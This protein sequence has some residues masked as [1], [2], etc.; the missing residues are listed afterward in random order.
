CS[1]ERSFERPLLALAPSSNAE[2]HNNPDQ[3][4]RNH[5]ND[6][7]PKVAAS[8]YVA[9]ADTP[10]P[11]GKH[12]RLKIQEVRAP[13]SLEGRAQPL[14]VGRCEL[15]EAAVAAL[16]PVDGTARAQ[17][18]LALQFADEHLSGDTAWKL[19][20]DDDVG[21]EPLGRQIRLRREEVEQVAGVELL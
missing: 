18:L 10:V 11:E 8:L 1:E 20:R 3:E 17:E 21:R 4:D 7:V 2:H 9:A 14:L 19:G 12:A 15:F 16:A 5:A 6:R 13:R